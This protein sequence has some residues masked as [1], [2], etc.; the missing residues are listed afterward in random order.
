MPRC[1][2]VILHCRMAVISGRRIA[3]HTSS[4]LLLQIVFPNIGVLPD[5]SILNSK[6]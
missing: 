3:I 4:S 6:V 1:D 5:S 2:T